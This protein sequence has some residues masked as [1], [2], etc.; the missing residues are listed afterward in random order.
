MCVDLMNELVKVMF[1]P[2]T[3]IDECLNGLVGIG[4]SIILSAF[5]DNLSGTKV[6]R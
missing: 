4:G 1:M 5:F 2:L 6:V 3:Q